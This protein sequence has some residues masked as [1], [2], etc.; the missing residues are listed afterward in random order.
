[1]KHFAVVICFEKGSLD[2]ALAGL[3]LLNVP[4]LPCNAELQACDTMS[5]L[6]GGADQSQ[7]FVPVRQSLCQLRYTSSPNL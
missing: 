7:S 4:S 5:S 2:V 6:F 3:E 1:M